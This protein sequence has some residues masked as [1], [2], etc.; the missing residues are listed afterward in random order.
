MENVKKEIK[1]NPERKGERLGI[2][3]KPRN[4]GIIYLVQPAELIGT[5]R[6][7][8]GYS[9]NKDLSRLKAY[10]K[11][12]RHICVHECFEPKMLEDEIKEK[13]NEHFTL[14]AGD[15]YFK[16]NDWDI[17]EAFNILVYNHKKKYKD[18]NRYN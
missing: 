4:E 16:A 12:L 6:Y 15:E 17:F 10:R 14:I 18:V 13:F 11:G 1:D 9:A 7:K 5:D 8:I 2:V 3:S